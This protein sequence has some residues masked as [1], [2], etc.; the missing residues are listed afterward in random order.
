MQKNIV[1]FV[2]V[3]SLGLLS[4]FCT[5]H[6]SIAMNKE[7]I[8]TAKG[9]GFAVV[10]LFTSEGC[11]SCPSAD[12]AVE[13]L[14]KKYPD[15]VYV[16]AFH[17]DYW[18]RLGW[19][20]AFSKP[21]YTQRQSEYATQFNLESIYTPQVVINGQIEFVGSDKTK[22]QS[23]V[24]AELKKEQPNNI[25]LSVSKKD[26]KTL[27]VN[28]KLN[29]AQQG[30]LHLA[31]VQDEATTDVKRGENGG[32]Q[33][34]HINLVRDYKTLTTSALEGRS[35]LKLP[36]GVSFPSLKIVAYLQDKSGVI[37]GVKRIGTADI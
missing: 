9:S 12:K 5:N 36:A 17:V 4:S 1:P 37:T 18:N 2:L 19:T 24:D 21:E 3:A 26:D 16:L 14:Q 25:E 28:Y 15:D 23:R 10:E 7:H 33:L 34:H 13:E 8:G 35:E 30:E 11:S 27:T 32:H 20:D 29:T 6:N 22:L 31:L